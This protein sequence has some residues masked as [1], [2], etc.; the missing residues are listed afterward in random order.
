MLCPAW[1]TLRLET[2]GFGVPVGQA[3]TNPG[4]VAFVA[5]RFKATAA[6][7][8]A[9]TPATP[10]TCTSIEVFDATGRAGAPRP[11][12]VS[13]IRVGVSGTN[14]AASAG[15]AA[16]AVFAATFI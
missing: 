3:V 10:A 11:V 1:V 7:P 12:R 2:V 16:P 15:T 9:G 6:T 14:F 4:K 8:V 5:V 13:R